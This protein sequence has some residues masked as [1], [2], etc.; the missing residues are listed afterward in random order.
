MRK[1]SAARPPPPIAALLVLSSSH[2][3]YTMKR[4]VQNLSPSSGKATRAPIDDS[5][6]ERIFC[7]RA[8]GA[9]DKSPFGT[10]LREKISVWEIREP[11]QRF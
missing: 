11:I 5:F 2:Y 7:Q 8:S 1:H 6:G 3:L 9:G 4:L 10:E